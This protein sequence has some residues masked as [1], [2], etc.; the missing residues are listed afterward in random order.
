MAAEDR[1]VLLRSLMGHCPRLQ[2]PTVKRA[3]T[4]FVSTTR[5]VSGCSGQP[6]PTMWPGLP[7]RPLPRIR[8]LGHGSQATVTV[9]QPI[10]ELRVQLRIR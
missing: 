2:T 7:R 1:S 3:G 4:S 6:L 9:R 10:E 8:Q 5:A